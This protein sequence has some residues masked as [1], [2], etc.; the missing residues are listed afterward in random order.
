MKA[1]RKLKANIEAAGFRLTD[2]RYLL[3][4]HVRGWISGGMARF[5]VG[6][7]PVVASQLNAD[8]MARVDERILRLAM[9]SPSRPSPLMEIIHNPRK[10]QP[11][12]G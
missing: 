3:N 6:G 4:S 5:S 11:P 10:H 2:I 9:R 12:E 7:A 8:Q 1:H